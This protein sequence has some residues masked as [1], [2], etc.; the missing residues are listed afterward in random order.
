MESPPSP[1]STLFDDVVAEIEAASDR[2]AFST[3]LAMNEAIEFSL[4]R[5]FR[6]LRTLAPLHQPPARVKLGRKTKK[7]LQSGTS[8]RRGTFFGMLSGPQRNQEHLVVSDADADADADARPAAGGMAPMPVA[9]AL[10]PILQKRGSGTSHRRGTFFGTF[11]TADPAFVS[12]SSPPPASPT[13]PAS[14]TTTTTTTTTLSMRPFSLRP[15]HHDSPFRDHSLV[16]AAVHR[17]YTYWGKNTRSREAMSRVCQM[18]GCG[19]ED[20]LLL[21]VKCAPG[22]GRVRAVVVN[23]D[24]LVQCDI[25]TVQWDNWGFH[26]CGGCR[27]RLYRIHAPGVLCV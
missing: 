21:R 3:N 18:R 9:T 10:A 7:S 13:S 25:G 24:F 16:R 22:P 17:S 5:T 6:A 4:A 23:Q 11:S 14:T 15:I 26:A 1:P 19:W 20:F 2:G 27:S 12:S 8:H